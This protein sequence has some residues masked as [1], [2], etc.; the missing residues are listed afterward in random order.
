[1]ARQPDATLTGRRLFPHGYHFTLHQPATD[2]RPV[3]D[4][5]VGSSTISLLVEAGC[6]DSRQRDAD[7]LAYTI[8][9]VG[10]ETIK[11]KRLHPLAGKQLDWTEGL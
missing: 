3:T 9:S 10:R 4:S 2:H 8:S 5:V 6:V 11:R 1:L 7:H